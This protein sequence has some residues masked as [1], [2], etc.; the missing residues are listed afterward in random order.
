MQTVTIKTKLGAHLIEVHAPNM[1]EAIQA[2]SLLAE[3][4]TECGLCQ[5]TDLGLHHREAQG[6]QF[7]G[8][9]CRRCGA[10]YPFGQRKVGGAL[11]PRGPWAHPHR[12]RADDDATLAGPES[13]D[14][15]KEAAAEEDRRKAQEEEAYYGRR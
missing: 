10:E 11:F 2:S 14:P 7:Y 5:A 6:Y 13:P 3:L 15:G 8:I 1:T 4:P 9:R 12:R